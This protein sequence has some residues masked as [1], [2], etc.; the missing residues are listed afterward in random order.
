VDSHVGM[1]WRGPGSGR[2]DL[3]L[4]PAPMPLVSRASLLKH[5][6]Y[7]GYYGEDVMLCAAV[8]RIGPFDNSFWSI[9]DRAEGLQTGHTVLRPGQR[10]VTIEESGEST[11]LELRSGPV[12][13]SLRLGQSEPIESLCPAGR[14]WGWTRKRAGVPVTGT[15]EVSGRRWQADG[16]GID[17]HS[18]GYHA[19]HTRWSWSAGV[20]TATDGRAVAWNLTAGINDPPEGSERTVWVD[21]RPAE[22]EPVV[23]LG[24]DGVRALGGDQLDFQFTGAER[25][26]NDDLGLV[27]SDYVHRFGTFTGKVGGIELA[28]AAGVMEDHDAVW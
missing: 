22:V 21:G 15:I 4:P 17:D 28:E 2:P 13:A 7:I 10:E 1:P 3:P 25:R 27:R 12:S 9:W 18:A 5:W 11:S 26:R 16:P 19:R 24:L 8:V 14:G 6:R 23:F 20:G